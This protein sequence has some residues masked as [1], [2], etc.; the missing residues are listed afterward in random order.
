MSDTALND[1]DMQGLFAPQPPQPP[2]QPAPPPGAPVVTVPVATPAPQ[3]PAAFTRQKPSFRPIAHPERLWGAYKSYAELNANPRRVA[4]DLLRLF[5]ANKTPITL[6]GPVG[7]R[8]TRSIQALTSE[9]DENGVPYQVVTIQPSTEDPTVIHGMMYTSLGEDGQTTVMKRSLPGVVDQIVRYNAETGGLTILFADE[10]TTCMPAQQHA[11]LG[12]L[13]H[14]IYGDVD[15]NPFIAIAMAANP[16]GTVSTVNDLGEQV[17]NRGGHIAWYGD[18]NLFME[19]W[20]SGFGSADR[21]PHPTTRWFV[22]E[23]LGQ[24]PD[25]AFRNQ[26]WKP[27]TLVPYALMEHTERVIT[28]YG[29]MLDLI[30]DN[31]SASPEEVREFYI[32]AVARALMGPDWADRAAVVA[33]MM[34]HAVDPQKYVEQVRNDLRPQGLDL[35]TTL[36]PQLDAWVGATNGTLYQKP[37]GTPFRQDEV[38][39]LLTRLR[40]ST[41]SGGFSLDCYMAAWIVAIGAPTPGGIAANVPHIRALAAIGQDAHARAVPGV[42]AGL[43][44]FVTDQVKQIVRDTAAGA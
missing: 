12:L 2:V 7:A 38:N 17:M 39:E 20:G 26:R 42:P 41:V 32:I 40:E 36:F 27:D 16:E 29:R 25:E 37:D 6:W 21:A 1:Q 18:A 28:E 43:P 3:V 24:K 5:L 8:K 14:G 11:M 4:V 9:V 10:M 44:A 33:N 19:E 30:R 15:I 23:L 13:T 31:L 34:K 22:K 35:N